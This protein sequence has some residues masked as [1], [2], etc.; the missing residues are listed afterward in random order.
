MVNNRCL[1][2]PEENCG[3]TMA[4]IVGDALLVD[5]LSLPQELHPSF[6]FNSQVIT[7]GLTTSSLSSVM[8]FQKCT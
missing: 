3:F 2:E 4:Q 1:T 6:H 5:K 8:V 7:K